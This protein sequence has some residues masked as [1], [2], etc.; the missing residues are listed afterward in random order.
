MTAHANDTG[1]GARLDSFRVRVLEAPVSDGIA[2]SFA[3][4]LQR[5]MVLVELESSDGLVGVGESW[6]NFPA[7]APVERVATLEQGVFPLLV[8]S[9]PRRITSLHREMTAALVPI[10]RQWGAPGPIMQAISAV[11]VALWDLRGKARD[12]AISWLGGG[13]VRDTISVYASSLGPDNVE[14]QGRRCATEGY[15]AVKVKLGFGRSRDE[16]ILATARSACGDGIALYAD[17]NQAWDL[18]EALAMASVLRDY[19]V[20]WVE[21]PIRGNRLADL[22]ILHERSGIG[23]ATGEN[24]YGREEFWPYAASPAIQVL[25]PDVAKTGGLTE[26][27]AICELAG[28]WGKQVIPHLYGGAVAFAATLQLAACAPC[29]TAIEYDVRDNP[30]RD[31]LLIDPPHPVSGSI[32]IPAGPGLGLDLNAAALDKY[33]EDSP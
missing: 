3:P 5:T 20:E 30:L 13:R 25:Q 6:A 1:R 18:P 17:A 29:V 4:L 26:A 15:N 12:T 7:W 9:D 33:S 11:D 16:G 10:S 8:G 22:E 19:G 28:M 24:L 27:F 14:A 2:M 23:I 21:E 32:D 31:G